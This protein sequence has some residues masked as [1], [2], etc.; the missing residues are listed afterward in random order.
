MTHS[1]K[2]S[3]PLQLT[4]LTAAVVFALTTWVTL[5]MIRSLITAWDLVFSMPDQAWL[6]PVITA[7][8]YVTVALAS[9]AFIAVSVTSSELTSA[10]A[11]R[12]Y[13]FLL[14]AVV[15]W[16]VASWLFRSVTT[17]TGSATFVFLCARLLWVSWLVF[18]VRGVR[19]WRSDPDTPVDA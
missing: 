10:S 3:K 5:P 1:K 18:L 16:S 6:Y 12:L 19:H 14:I 13:L 2:L 11:A 9:A 8:I 15:V 17:Q 7:C 4:L